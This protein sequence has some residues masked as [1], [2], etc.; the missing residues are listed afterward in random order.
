MKRPFIFILGL[1]LVVIII[2]IISSLLLYN[3][4]DDETIKNKIP[5]VLKKVTYE[6]IDKNAPVIDIYNADENKTIKMNI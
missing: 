6:K 5:N 3:I 1:S 2:P 4:S